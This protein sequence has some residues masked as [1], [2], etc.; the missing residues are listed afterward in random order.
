MVVREKE[1][2]LPI[3]PKSPGSQPQ[4]QGS[5]HKE[6]SCWSSNNSLVKNPDY[7]SPK[8]RITSYIL[9]TGNLTSPK[10]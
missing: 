5:L 6:S 3:H 4:Q 7:P 10:C 8:G 1:E 2:V 9:C